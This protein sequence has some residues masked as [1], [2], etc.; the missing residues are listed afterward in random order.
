M[1]STLTKAFL[2]AAIVVLAMTGCRPHVYKAQCQ[3]LGYEPGSL[4]MAQCA[5]RRMNATAQAFA[6]WRL[7]QPTYHYAPPR[8]PRSC[9]VQRFGTMATVNCN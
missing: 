6:A 3:E 4:E 7:S 2:I 5:E 1:N 8:R 9:F